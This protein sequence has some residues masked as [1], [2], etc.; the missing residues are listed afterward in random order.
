MQ[1]FKILSYKKAIENYNSKFETKEYFNYINSFSKNSEIII[2]LD[3][4]NMSKQFGDDTKIFNENFY[5]VM[6]KIISNIF[7]KFKFINVAYTFKDEISILI[8]R[9]NVENDKIY[10]RYEKIISLVTGYISALFTKEICKLTNNYDAF[11]FDARFILIDKDEIQDYFI[12]RY[13]LSIRAFVDKVE[14]HFELKHNNVFDFETLKQLLA[15]HNLNYS[16]ISKYIYGYI[17]YKEKS[18]WIVKSANYDNKYL[19]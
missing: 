17:G 15:N 7:N 11:Y 4:K 5:N 8:D 16:E 13:N 10:N 3:G 18:Q 12:S 1:N 9:K 14:S 19:K 6:Y 2:R